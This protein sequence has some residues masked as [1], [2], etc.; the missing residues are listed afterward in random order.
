MGGADVGELDVTDRMEEQMERVARE[1]R[2]WRTARLHHELHHN[3]LS[4]DECAT[5]LVEADEAES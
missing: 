2:E 1:E 5:C 3:W 4:P